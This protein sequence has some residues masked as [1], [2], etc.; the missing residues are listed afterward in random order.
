MEVIYWSLSIGSHDAKQ[1]LKGGTIQPRVE[2]RERRRQP[3]SQ[4]S[5]GG[6]ALQFSIFRLKTSVRLQQHL[7]TRSP[8]NS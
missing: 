7:D 4:V 1:D 2:T 6:Q 5:F 8:L 3:V